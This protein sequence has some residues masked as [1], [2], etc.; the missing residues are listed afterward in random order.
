MH[1]GDLYLFKSP[2]AVP[3]SFWVLCY[4][5]AMKGLPLSEENGEEIVTAVFS[6]P[7]YFYHIEMQLLKN[8]K[9]DR[10]TDV[11]RSTRNDAIRNFRMLRKPKL[12]PWKG[13]SYL[14]N[15]TNYTL[16]EI[17]R[18]RFCHAIPWWKNVDGM[19]TRFATELFLRQCVRRVAKNEGRLK[20]ICPP[21]P[22]STV[23]SFTFRFWTYIHCAVY[24][25]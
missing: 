9:A 21:S 15:D 1:R 12:L 2:R 11:N 23:A 6:F 3:V 14:S 4:T 5:S 24:W 7:L 25:E 22:P 10:S 20:A 16:M 17:E 13:K 19:T 8:L 18:L